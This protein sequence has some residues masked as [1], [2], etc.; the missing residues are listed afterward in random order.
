MQVDILLQ[1]DTNVNYKSLL[2]C[3]RYNL[4]EGKNEKSVH[5]L[6]YSL[7]DMDKVSIDAEETFALILR[8]TPGKAVGGWLTYTEKTGLKSYQVRRSVKNISQISIKPL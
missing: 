8:N 2:C 6:P 3:D 5:T 1:N 4:Q 7:S